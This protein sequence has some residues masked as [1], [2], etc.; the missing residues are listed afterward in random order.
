MAEA[1]WPVSARQS[2]AN[3]HRPREPLASVW[4]GNVQRRTDRNNAGR[5]DIVVR[6]VVVPLDV[7]KVYCLG[8]PGLL[9]K[10]SHISVEIGIVNDTADV[11]L[12]VAVIDRVEA[13]EGAE[14]PPICF[15]DA[16]AE[17]IPV[18]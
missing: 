4:A 12:E 18:R 15:Y 1:E 9:V 10:I 6:D 3:V 14:E 16:I 8:D 11:A 13:N 17:E 5:V 2:K 7:I